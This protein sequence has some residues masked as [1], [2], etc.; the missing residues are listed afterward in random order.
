MKENTD[1]VANIIF[2]TRRGTSHQTSFFF[3]WKSAATQI[4][5]GSDENWHKA[6]SS[7]KLDTY[8]FMPN[9]TSVY[10]KEKKKNPYSKIL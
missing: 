6:Q 4:T 9:H 10:P 8:G 5:W 1:S 7:I 3:F 2:C